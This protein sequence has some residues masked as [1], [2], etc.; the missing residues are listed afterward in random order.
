MQ[1]LDSFRKPPCSRTLGIEIE[2]LIESS[3][4][5]SDYVGFFYATYDGSIVRDSFMQTGREFVSQPLTTNWLIKEIKRLEKRVGPWDFNSSCGIHVHVSKK[6]LTKKRAKLIQEFYDS[7]SDQLRSIIFG[8]GHNQ[9]TRRSCDVGE[10]S[11]YR[12]VNI[13]NDKTIELRMFSSGNAAWAC[14]CVKLADYL[15]TFAHQLNVD[16]VLAFSEIN[17]VNRV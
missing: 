4:S 12:A 7:L 11:R 6:W 10:H 14:Y 5:I 15:V 9:Y 1:S 8:R 16:A 3:R 2:C 13:T 17:G